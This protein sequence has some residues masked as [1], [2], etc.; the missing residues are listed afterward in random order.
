M[1]FSIEQGRLYRIE[2][3]VSGEVGGVSKLA[4]V[5]VPHRKRGDNGAPRIS[6][7]SDSSGVVK[8]KTSLRLLQDWRMSE[9]DE[10]EL[11]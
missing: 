2:M 10:E 1:G 3:G 4:I 6:G 7:E 5:G 8:L 9:S 11:L